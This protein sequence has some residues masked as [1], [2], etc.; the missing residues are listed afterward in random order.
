MSA[1]YNRFIVVMPLPVNVDYIHTLPFIIDYN[2]TM[3]FLN[4]K[5]DDN[6]T[7]QSYCTEIDL[8]EHIRYNLKSYE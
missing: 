4:E 2:K 6:S 5:K 1:L 8:Y 7:V 3:A